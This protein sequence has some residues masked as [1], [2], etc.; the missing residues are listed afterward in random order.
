M[1][2]LDKIQNAISN[3]DD[4]KDIKN[5]DWSTK[6]GDKNASDNEGIE[7]LYQSLVDSDMIKDY[8]QDDLRHRVEAG[9]EYDFI[10]MLAG[11]AIINK[12]IETVK[13]FMTDYKLEIGKDEIEAAEESGCEK[14]LKFIKAHEYM[15]TEAIN[16]PIDINIEKDDLYDGE[17]YKWY[18]GDYDGT[19]TFSDDERGLTDIEWNQEEVPGN[20][21]DIEDKI[22]DKISQ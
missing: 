3:D 18:V 8:M 16:K 5:V 15:R 1:G 6:P 13:K 14:M 19:V 10:S 22:L 2:I 7:K 11:S 20:Y 21:E 17:R 12:D 9:D 4:T